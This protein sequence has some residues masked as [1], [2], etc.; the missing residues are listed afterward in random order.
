ML[1]ESARLRMAA[2]GELQSLRIQRYF[3]DAYQYGRGFLRQ[4][5]FLRDQSEQGLLEA[6]DLR[7]KMNEQIR[8]ALQANPGILGLYLVFE[9]NALDGQDELFA[10]QSALGSN[11][12]GR[13][14][15]YWSQPPRAS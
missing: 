12:S 14:A 15:V 11:D 4:A 2:R 1:E 9:P 3:M 8:S 10:G 13:F 6:S 7:E 5:A